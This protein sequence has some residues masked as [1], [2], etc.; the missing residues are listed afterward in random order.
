VNGKEHNIDVHN[1][2]D[3]VSFAL[4][5]LHEITTE[6]G[7]NKWNRAVFSIIYIL[8]IFAD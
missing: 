6:G 5:E 2:D 1:F 8:D 7:K 3:E 4:M